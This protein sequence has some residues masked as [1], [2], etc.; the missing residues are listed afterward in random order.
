MNF[1]GKVFIVLVLI[2]SIMF[3]C[4]AVVV[5]TT[6]KNWKD[7][8][9]GPGGLKARLTEAQTQFDSLKTQHDRQVEQLAAEEQAAEQQAAKLETERNLLVQTNASIQGELDQLK[10]Q[11]RDH[12]AAIASTQKN[13]EDL[14]TQVS[15]LGRQKRDSELARDT[16]YLQM[17]AAT[18]D[19]NQKVGQLESAVE[20]TKQLTEQVSNMTQ[21]MNANGINPATNASAVTPT[22]DGVVSRIQ[23]SG[24]TQL[25]EVTIGADDGLKAGDTLEVF[26]GSKYL[27]RLNIMQTSPDKSVGQVNRRFQQGQIQEGDRVATRLTF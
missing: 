27:G 1:L 23:R 8:V 21:V 15:E 25:V 14:S 20:R 16:Q 11:Q 19:R 13:N 7:L 9:E 12:T 24:G 6:H 18:E 5:Y 26:R 22:V 3:M 4:F 10:Q 2:L 17:L